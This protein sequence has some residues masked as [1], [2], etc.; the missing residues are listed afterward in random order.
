MKKAIAVISLT[1]IMGGSPL[2]AQSVM[3]SIG[4]SLSVRE[5]FDLSIDKINISFG[6]NEVGTET[7]V[8]PAQV[9]KC[10]I[11]ANHGVQ[12][13]VTMAATPLSEPGGGIIPAANFQY[14]HTFDNP[15]GNEIP[16]VGNTLPVPTVQQTVFEAGPNIYSANTAEFGMGFKVIIPPAQ[17]VGNY[18]TTLTINLVD[19]I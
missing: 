19:G 18:S 13:H 5:M 12:W 1:I 16:S 7:P 2:F 8:T 15:E 3:R 4:A 17:K 9:M 11:V 6:V 10:V 14:F